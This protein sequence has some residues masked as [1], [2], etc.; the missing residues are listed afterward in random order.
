[1]SLAACAAPCAASIA[2]NEPAMCIRERL[3]KEL[4]DTGGFADS[5]RLDGNCGA[6]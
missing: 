1:M 3:L 5:I 4:G 2:L 6:S